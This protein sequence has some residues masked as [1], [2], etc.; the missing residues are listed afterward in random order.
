MYEVLASTVLVL[1]F[2]F[3]AY[4]VLGGFLAWR[5]PRALW[6]HLAAAAWGLAVVSIPLTCPLTLVEHWA[7]RKAG[8]TGVGRGFIDQYIEGVLYPERYTHLLQVLVG[9]LVA[10]SYAGIY[11]RRRKRRN[12][13]P[14]TAAGSEEMSEPTATV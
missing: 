8:E 9:V 13:T 1:H 5:W 4:V 10:V 2:C 6:P 3:L 7:R 11:L 12:T 14:N